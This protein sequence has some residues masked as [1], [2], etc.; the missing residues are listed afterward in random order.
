MILTTFY[1][2]QKEENLREFIQKNN[3]E[4]VVLSY[5][6]LRDISHG[7]VNFG[8]IPPQD[9]SLNVFL[10]VLSSGKVQSEIFTLIDW[11]IINMYSSL[12]VETSKLKMTKE[13]FEIV[14]ENIPVQDFRLHPYMGNLL[15]ICHDLK[16]P[17]EDRL[18]SENPL[19]ILPKILRGSKNKLIEALNQF[20]A[21]RESF[22]SQTFCGCIPIFNSQFSVK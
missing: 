1:P 12:E 18:F 6:P 15:K 11:E 2:H 8:N 19:L 21:I 17:G 3:S 7:L 16:L 13:E 9:D 22:K 10:S 4:I 20:S 14:Q 5:K